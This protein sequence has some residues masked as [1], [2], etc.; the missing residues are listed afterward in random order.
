MGGTCWYQLNHCSIRRGSKKSHAATYFG[1]CSYG[2]LKPI[3]AEYVGIK[4]KCPICNYELV[5][6]RYLGEFSKLSPITHRGET[7][8]MYGTNGVPLW[9]IVVERKFNRGSGAY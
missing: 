3:N 8:A 5:R 1:V 2:K 9:E 7:V 6:I 4:Q